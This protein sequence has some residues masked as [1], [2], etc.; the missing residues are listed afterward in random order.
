[1]KLKK[2][3]SQ[4]SSGVVESSL[5]FSSQ[6]M[7]LG[8]SVPFSHAAYLP[9]NVMYYNPPKYQVQSQIRPV[10][11]VSLLNV[12]FFLEFCHLNFSKAE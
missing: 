10:I 8:L 11:H 4:P 3:Q 1:M 7:L 5:H 9:N 2:S 6:M 12:S